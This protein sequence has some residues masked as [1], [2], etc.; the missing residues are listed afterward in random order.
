MRERR[1]G[2]SLAGS[3]SELH[4]A[5]ITNE[6]RNADY[7]WRR[8]RAERSALG[9]RRTDYASVSFLCPSL[10][11]FGRLKPP[12]ASRQGLPGTTSP[13]GRYSGRWMPAVTCVTSRNLDSGGRKC[14]RLELKSAARRRPGAGLQRPGRSAPISENARTLRFHATASMRGS[15]WRSTKPTSLENDASAW[16]VFSRR[17]LQSRID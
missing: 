16:A 3:L 12:G 6:A 11:C 8:N 4:T 7:D 13:A 17:G 1:R 15:P 14:R 10:I 9:G 5:R 2:P